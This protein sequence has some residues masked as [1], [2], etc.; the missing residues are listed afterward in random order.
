MRRRSFLLLATTASVSVGA[1]GINPTGETN[2]HI[3]GL[4]V[5]STAWKDDPFSRGAYSVRTGKRPD[6]RRFERIG[7][8][9]LYM[10]GDAFGGGGVAGAFASG[11]AAATAV[12]TDA[13]HVESAAIIGAGL[14]GAAAARTLRDGG[15]RVQVFEAR[16]TVGGRASLLR[17]GGE[18]RP[19]GTMY[20]PT[21]CGELFDQ[22]SGLGLVSGE[23]NRPRPLQQHPWLRS[24]PVTPVKDLTTYV[25]LLLGRIPVNL[26]GPVV[27]VESHKS[28]V[29]IE[30][31]GDHIK[32]DRVVVTVPPSVIVAGGI[33]IKLRG[34][35]ALLDQFSVIDAERIIAEHNE[36][37]LYDLQAGVLR[38]ADGSELRGIDVQP[39]ILNRT[40]VRPGES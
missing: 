16:P 33:Q 10:G 30:L 24:G 3:G 4:S 6:N 2:G 21:E 12:M 37:R 15:V 31:G 17:N 9:W 11:V 39:R 14:A 8:S 13:P 23:I 26:S 25:D 38:R 28:H 5:R 35:D 36:D 20:V 19:L 7:G 40:I 22:L 34:I 1:L 29:T 18:A 27:S 32:F